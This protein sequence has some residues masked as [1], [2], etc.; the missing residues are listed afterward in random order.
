MNKKTKT[1]LKI[2]F[3][4]LGILSFLGAVLMLFLRELTKTNII[5]SIILFIVGVIFTSPFISA[6]INNKDPF[7]K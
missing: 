3:L 4:F 2:I 6:K 7:N 1:I 5:L